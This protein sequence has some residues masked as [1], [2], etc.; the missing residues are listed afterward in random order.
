MNY[1]RYV[2]SLIE[3]AWD[4]MPTKISITDKKVYSAVVVQNYS[5]EYSMS[6]SVDH[7]RGNLK[8]FAFPHVVFHELSHVWDYWK[9]GRLANTIE[10]KRKDEIYADLCGIELLMDSNISYPILRGVV[11]TTLVAIQIYGFRTLIKDLFV[12]DKQRDLYPH[13][14]V[15][16]WYLWK[17]GMKYKKRKGE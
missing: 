10:Q 8:R 15:R 12:W 5:G 11:S 4:E 13:P 3:S 7:F 16:A 17:H 6:F 14:F 9:H 2:K 1:K